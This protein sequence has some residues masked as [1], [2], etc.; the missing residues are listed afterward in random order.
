MTEESERGSDSPYPGVPQAVSFGSRS[1]VFLANPKSA[2]F[3]SLSSVSVREQNRQN[4]REIFGKYKGRGE[5]EGG[6]EEEEGGE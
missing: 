6:G 3:M 5:R 1:V 2:I 4:I